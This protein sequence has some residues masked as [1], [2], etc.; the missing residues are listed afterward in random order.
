MSSERG[1][2]KTV[3]GR[4]V[5][6][7]MDKTITVRQERLVKHAMYGKYV[8]R[9]TSY[10]AHDENNQARMGDLVEIALTR[11][12]SKTKNW[13]LVRVLRSDALAQ[14]GDGEGGEA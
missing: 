14:M 1:Q 11:P 10:K 6:D 12:I 7:K 8:R 13:R 9:A 3:Q 4:V 2:R 5:S